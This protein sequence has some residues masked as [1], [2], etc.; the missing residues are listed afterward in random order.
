MWVGCGFGCIL[1]GILP[2]L[3]GFLTTTMDDSEYTH[4]SRRHA[5]L[6]RPRYCSQGGNRGS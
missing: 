5:I 1:L 3:V 2:S 6:S 4:P